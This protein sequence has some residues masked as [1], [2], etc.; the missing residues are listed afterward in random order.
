[1][2]IPVGR[3]LGRRPVLSPVAAP[4]TTAA[5]F[6]TGLGDA[7]RAAGG[8]VD[9]YREKI[10]KRENLEVETRFAEF[11]A[12][13]EAD[14]DSASRN[15]APGGTGF[16]EQTGRLYEDTG[17]AFLEAVP[18][19]L[20]HVY[21]SRLRTTGTAFTQAALNYQRSE[22]DRYQGERLDSSLATLQSQIS[23][24]PSEAA[25]LTL[26][27]VRT[28]DMADLPATVKAERKK[29]FREKSKALELVAN[30]R[31]DSAYRQRFLDRDP[32][33]V[34]S[35][36][37]EVFEATRNAAKIAQ[38]DAEAAKD[39]ASS[40]E[41]DRLLEEYVQSGD[42]DLEAVRANAALNSR[43]KLTLLDRDRADDA[44]AE[45]AIEREK[46]E[47][48]REEEKAFRDA[49]A[50][51]QLMIAE[52]GQVS[53]DAYE[54]LPARYALPVA[55]ATESARRSRRSEAKAAAAA[56]SKSRKDWYY[57]E[58]AGGRTFDAQAIAADDTLD[59]DDKIALQRMSNTFRDRSSA[60]VRDELSLRAL[61]GENVTPERIIADPTM[62]NGDKRSLMA[63]YNT[64]NKDKREAAQV[65][66][67]VAN[68]VKFNPYV[69]TDRKAMDSV[70]ASRFQKTDPL[71]DAK[72]AQFVLGL[73][74]NSGVIGN[75]AVASIQ[76]AAQS[77]DPD[78]MVAAMNFAAALDQAAP[79]ALRAATGG[80]E[81]VNL[82]EEYQTEA[83][84]GYSDRQAAETMIKR[85]SL[86]MKRAKDVLA[87]EIKD[88]LDGAPALDDVFDGS[89]F[90]DPK[91]GATPEQRIDMTALYRATLE[92]EYL[93]SGGVPDIAYA[94]AA[95]AMKQRYGVSNITGERVATEF[96][97]ENYHA[98][99]G[100]SYG[101][102][103]EQLKKDV[104]ALVGRD[105]G[106]DKVSLIATQDSASRVS[107]GLAPQYNI[108][109]FD[110]DG[111]IAYVSADKV[112]EFDAESA[113]DE[114]AANASKVRKDAARVMRENPVTTGETINLPG[115]FNAVR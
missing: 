83:K 57:E 86:E 19:R 48:G 68:G 63:S 26:Y 9:Q 34:A 80:D 105:V 115:S 94:R 4:Q 74:G 104:D 39:E 42:I 21:E 6:S 73:S 69:S 33:L 49:S 87:P 50:A 2:R 100:G 71:E 29:A 52:G 65:V 8:L 62:N 15:I 25:A 28:I 108:V 32:E 55:R 112:F 13:R 35:M 92:S 45:A 76:A 22:S 95:K 109:V 66:A 97:P 51:L 10:E 46:A 23:A 12:N 84:S 1:M 90:I 67:D 72:A 113:L 82:L 59:A 70:Y 91:A 81:V 24:K 18:E 103:S 44:R 53:R 17:K 47:A 106:L 37:P 30:V 58:M 14:L 5:D 98:A 56:L 111:E 7:A 11:V 43:A 31:G 78:R 77:G 20:R 107:Q 3:D 60:D 75:N 89:I 54:G 40:A 61:M 27:G 64:T 16:V 38:R 79:G 99:I 110:D 41:Y 114:A 93:K 101:W 96:P 85:R 102:M 88:M 36:K